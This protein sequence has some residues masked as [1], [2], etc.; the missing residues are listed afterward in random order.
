[1]LFNSIQFIAG[2]F[3]VVV[4][5]YFVLG[6]SSRKLAALWLA[7]ASLFFYGWWN[8]SFVGLLLASV[9]FNYSAG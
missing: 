2:F 9:A 1:M 3:P 6:R 4:V 7:A 5:G 8:I